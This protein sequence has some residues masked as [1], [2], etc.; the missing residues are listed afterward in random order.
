MK[1][2]VRS[3][4]RWLAVAG[5]ALGLTGCAG[6]GDDLPELRAALTGATNVVAV[7]GAERVPVRTG[8]VLARAADDVGDPP[9]AEDVVT[10]L[11]RYVR[12]IGEVEVVGESE[13]RF[14]DTRLAG[15]D[16]QAG[17]QERRHRRNHRHAGRGARSSR[18]PPG[19]LASF[20]P[21]CRSAIGAGPHSP[22]PDEPAERRRRR[23][24]RG[25]AESSARL[26]PG[27]AAAPPRDLP[28][29]LLAVA[30]GGAS[31]AFVV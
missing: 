8:G 12:P 6:K 18:G 13:A 15:P 25:G 20:S 3:W 2:A 14:V 11:K 19:A 29:P 10:A 26:A 27:S 1:T 17:R 5:L 9:R 4:G 28:R 30:R 22:A 7:G 16:R 23:S 24:L 21:F 31:R